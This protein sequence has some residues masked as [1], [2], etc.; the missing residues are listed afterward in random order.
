MTETPT[1]RNS[2][3]S[4][5]RDLVEGEPPSSRARGALHSEGA[6]PAALTGPVGRPTPER[7]QHPRPRTRQPSPA[8]PFLSRPSRYPSVDRTPNQRSGRICSRR[9]RKRRPCAS[10][11]WTLGAMLSSGVP[12]KTRSGH[13]KDATRSAAEAIPAGRVAAG[14]DQQPMAIASHPTSAKAHH[15]QVQRHLRYAHLAPHDR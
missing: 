8:W 13:R 4:D 14:R 11:V 3:S 12:P 7:L 2:R 9:G 5:S 10:E 1:R 15:E 6:W